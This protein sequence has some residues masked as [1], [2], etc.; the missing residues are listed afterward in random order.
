[1]R[2]LGW[3]ASRT[4]P[5]RYAVVGHLRLPSGRA[6]S[7]EI[8]VVLDRGMEAYVTP[9]GG[10][11]ALVAL[12]GDRSLMRRFAGDLAGGY[13][14]VLRS[15][16]RLRV[17]LDGAELLPGVHATGPFGARSRT[18]AGRGVLLVGDA[19]GFLDPITGEGMAT[20][21]QQARAAA[22]VID[23]ALGRHGVP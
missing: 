9:L 19:A 16:R 1:R 15:E 8:E 20:A 4:R 13:G 2:L 11:E 18:V 14:R 17:M 10:G 22:G 5:R 7:P 23:S 21:L 12:L 6:L 3:D